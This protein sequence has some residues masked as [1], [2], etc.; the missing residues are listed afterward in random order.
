MDDLKEWQSAAHAQGY[1][2]RGGGIPHRGEGEAELLTCLPRRLM[3]VLDLG[4]GSGRL[5]SIVKEVQP[6]AT[7]VALDFS[8]T[9]LAALRQRFGSGSGV[10]IVAHDLNDT[11]PDTLGR[12]DAVVS[13]FAIHHVPH[14]RKRALYCEVFH[15]LESGGVFCNLEHVASSTRALH[16]R[17]LAALNMTPA[18]EDRSNQLL[19]CETQLRWLRDIGF[20][21]VDCHWK[22]RE[23]ALLAGRKP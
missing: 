17:F 4:S 18:E 7:A 16:E 14:A 12:F 21:D 3:R 2:E 8:D 10:S 22:W 15:L 6:D 9:M 11:L 19:D 5:L 23:L 1:L 20:A 13:S